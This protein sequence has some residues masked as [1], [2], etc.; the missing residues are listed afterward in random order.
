[1]DLPKERVMLMMKK[2]YA[3]FLSAAVVEDVNKISSALL[4]STRAVYLTSIP[5]FKFHESETL[6][7][8]FGF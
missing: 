5:S 2:C 1:M 4:A 6:P 7:V 8:S 3:E